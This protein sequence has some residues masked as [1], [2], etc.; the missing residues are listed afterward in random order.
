MILEKNFGI[1]AKFST[2]EKIF[3]LDD[4]LTNFG[5]SPEIQKHFDHLANMSSENQTSF[6]AS[7]T[8]EGE[9][10]GQVYYFEA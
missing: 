6:T 5:K 1:S 10:S 7:V 2:V 3:H 8:I 4:S 9:K